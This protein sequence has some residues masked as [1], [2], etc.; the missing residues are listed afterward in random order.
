MSSAPG[1]HHPDQ[2]GWE[3]RL[4]T[5]TTEACATGNGRNDAEHVVFIQGSLFPL[6]ETDIFVAEVNVDEAAQFTFF[7]VKVIA[8][9]AVLRRNGGAGSGS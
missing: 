1:I 8:Q 6:Q 5:D 3:P 9:T 7:V 2:S 4:A